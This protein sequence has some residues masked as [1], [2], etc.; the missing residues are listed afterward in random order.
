[1]CEVLFIMHEKVILERY[2]SYINCFGYKG[3]GVLFEKDAVN[4]YIEKMTNLDI[5]VLEV[6]KVNFEIKKIVKKIKEKFKEC[7]ILILISE[8]N[9]DIEKFIC[10]FSIDAYL[11]FPVLPFQ[12]L[13]ALYCLSNF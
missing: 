10:D 11:T 1:M 9:G 3:K 5:L 7:K 13:R 2:L 8:M 4:N 12:I 6:E